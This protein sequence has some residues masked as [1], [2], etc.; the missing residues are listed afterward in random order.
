MADI[1]IKELMEAGVHF[2]H[3]TK[4]W[5]PKMKPYIF[6][7]RNGIYIIDLQQTVTH[8]KKATDFARRLAAGGGTILFIGTKDQAKE[9]IKE[10]AIKCGMPY[11]VERWLGGMLTNFETIRKSISRLKELQTLAE[12]GTFDALSKKEVTKLSK[13]KFKL[14]KNLGGI[15]DMGKLPNAVFIVDTQKEH[16]ALKEARRLGLPIIAIVD[17]NCDPTGIEY[18]I[19]GNDD[20]TRSVHLVTS[21]IAKAL[22]EGAEEYAARKQAI[23]EEAAAEKEG[24]RQASV[25]KKE[26]GAKAK[27][28]MP[29]E[30]TETSEPPAKE[31]A[32]E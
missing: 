22:D 29:D 21:A 16:T 9:I 7:S 2:G 17:T 24:K 15:Q 8:F 10:E 3:Q 19:P 26:E 25:A 6:D 5:N 1:T 12:D 32:K 14:E 13:E 27:T 23:A 11:I 4:R 31:A 30:G 28:T 20:A 18:V